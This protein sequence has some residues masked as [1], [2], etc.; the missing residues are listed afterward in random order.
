MVKKKDNLSLAKETVGV[1]VANMAGHGVLGTLGGLPGMPTA[2][3]GAM[4]TAG[5]GL[6]L[7]AVG[8]TAK[9]GLGLANSLGGNTQ[10][11]KTKSDKVNRILG[12]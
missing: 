10:K 5:A 2:A 9:V 6:N 7:V 3:T 12:L 1:G 4:N 8:Q 11:K